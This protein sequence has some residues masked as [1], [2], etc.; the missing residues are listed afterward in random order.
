MVWVN[1]DITTNSWHR[2]IVML[3]TEYFFLTFKSPK[4]S[5]SILLPS[6]REC[7]WANVTHCVIPWGHTL[8]S[9]FRAMALGPPF[10][11]LS[12][13]VGCFLWTWIDYFM[14]L[15]QVLSSLCN[16]FML[17]IFNLWQESF[18]CSAMADVLSQPLAHVAVIST[19]MFPK[20]GL[21]RSSC[22]TQVFLI[23]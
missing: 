23:H 16:T 19:S 7:A 1:W 17:S 20:P 8:E 12:R 11:G 6:S 22:L 3:L 10:L 21:Q 14:L 4:F 9:S 18:R 5:A 2:K 15:L 13:R